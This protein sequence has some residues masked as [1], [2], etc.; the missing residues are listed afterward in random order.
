MYAVIAQLQ[1]HDYPTAVLCEEL[2]V[3]RSRFY[4][5]QRG[6]MTRRA[7]RD[8][9]LKPLIREVFREHRGRYGAR[10]IARELGRRGHACGVVRV[11]RLLA[12]MGLLAIQPK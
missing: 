11:G 9:D 2:D 1:Q 3:H 12:E 5:W 6:S 8:A 7:E 10:R 4:A